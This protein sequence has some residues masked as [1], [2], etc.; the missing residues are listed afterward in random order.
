MFDISPRQAHSLIL[1][2]P[3]VTSSVAEMNNSVCSRSL[4]RELPG[5]RLEDQVIGSA[6][7]RHKPLKSK[8]EKDINA[9]DGIASGESLHYCD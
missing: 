3:S 1:D 9:S 8:L 2:S 6:L 5:C 7:D 4:S